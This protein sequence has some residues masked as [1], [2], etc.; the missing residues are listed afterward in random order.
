M[1]GDRVIYIQV[2]LLEHLA[3]HYMSLID[4]RCTD[5]DDYNQISQSAL[6]DVT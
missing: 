3:E 5:C 1:Y 4:L 2:N 6:R